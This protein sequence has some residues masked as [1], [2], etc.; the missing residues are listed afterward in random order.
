MYTS[1][2]QPFEKN[3]LVIVENGQSFEVFNI[4]YFAD[5]NPLKYKFLAPNAKL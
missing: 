2:Q 5:L 3:E 4:Q 1:C